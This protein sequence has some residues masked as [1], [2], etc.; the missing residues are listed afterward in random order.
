MGNERAGGIGVIVQFC[1]GRR[2]SQFIASGWHF[3]ILLDFQDFGDG[4][5][6]EDT[7]T[8]VKENLLG[9]HSQAANQL[10]ENNT[11]H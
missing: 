1:S 3:T 7:R 5:P 8:M 6:H 11:Q 4:L 2:I 10:I 9:K